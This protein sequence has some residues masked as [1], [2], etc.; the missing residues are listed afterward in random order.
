LRDTVTIPRT[1]VMASYDLAIEDSLHSDGVREITDA[2]AL[3][4]TAAWQ[5]PTG[6]GLTFARL[7]SWN[8][9]ELSDVLEAIADART[10]YPAN[11]PTADDRV[12][13][14]MLATWAINGPRS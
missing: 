12:A 2:S 11:E 14:D 8:T 13:L 9:V 5:G 3:A 10:Q 7:T 4:I 6:F 1:T